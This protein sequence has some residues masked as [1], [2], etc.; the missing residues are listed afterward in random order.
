MK[1]LLLFTLLFNACFAF[2]Q[3]TYMKVNKTDGTSELFPINEIQE[4]KFNDLVGI[5]DFGKWKNAFIT[6]NKLKCYPNPSRTDVTIEYDL[7]ETGLVE[8]C[9]YDNKGKLVDKKLF[10]NQIP[11]K[12]KYVFSWKDMNN[13][14][15]PSGIYHCNVLFKST[16][17]SD[18][19]LLIK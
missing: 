19:I 6:F 9:I 2:A 16:V 12:N 17:L 7:P 13:N 11:G 18:K 14:S 3:T 8:L 1:I 5:E 10:K 15:L 4:I